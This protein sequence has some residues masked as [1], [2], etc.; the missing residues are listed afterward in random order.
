[1]DSISDLKSY[2]EEAGRLLDKAKK[3][4]LIGEFPFQTPEYMENVFSNLVSTI[5][6]KLDPKNN[7]DFTERYKVIIHNVTDNAFLG[8][9]VSEEKS[10]F[11][12]GFEHFRILND[13]SNPRAVSTEGYY[14]AHSFEPTKGKVYS[15]NLRTSAISIEDSIQRIDPRLDFKT[16]TDRIE[17]YKEGKI[18]LNEPI[19][20]FEHSELDKYIYLLAYKF[21]GYAMRIQRIDLNRILNKYEGFTRFMEY[22]YIKDLLDYNTNI[23][24]PFSPVGD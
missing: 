21:P 9:F 5:N 3:R 10:L 14:L 1:M 11:Y 2:I 18:K 12:G 22:F 17:L 15:I 19:L 8:K 23:V 20:E 16:E 7:N 13:G 24:I 6:I 4:N